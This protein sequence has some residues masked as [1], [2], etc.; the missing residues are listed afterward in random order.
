M[1]IIIPILSQWNPVGLNKA[2]SDIRRAEGGF[3]KFKAGIKSLAVPAA[4]TFAAITAGAF[5]TIKAAEEAQVANRRLANVL[6]QMGYANATNRVLDYADALSTQI[7]KEDESIKLVQA[8]LATFKNL[9]KTIDQ[10]NGAF[11][12]ATRAA[13]DLAAA[14]FGEAEQ[15]ATQLGKALQDPIKGITALARSGVTFT[16]AEKEKIKALVESGKLLEAQDVLL[17]AIETQVGGTAEATATASEKMKIRFGEMKEALG[18]QLLPAFERLAPIVEKIF[19]FIADNSDVFVTLTAVIAGTTA[20]VIA[21]NIALA[22]NPFTYIVLG[23][24]AAIALIALAIMRFE[25]LKLTVFNIAAGIGQIFV[26]TFNVVADA[27]TR[28]VNEFVRTYN[29]YLLPAIKTFKKDAQALAEVDFT[30]PFDSANA[31]ID[32]FGAANR[33]T[34]SELNYNIDAVGAVT[35][36]IGS[37]TPALDDLTNEYDKT[38]DSADKVTEAMK[39]QKKAAQDAAKA[40]VDDLEKSLQSAE[41]QL[42]AVK[43]KF[44]DLKDTISGSVTDVIDFGGAL[45]SGN[46]VQGLVSQANAAKTFA[47]KVKQLIQLGLSER[48]IRQVLD[49]GFESGTLIADQ[50]ILGGSTVVQQINELVAS[51]AAVAD[52]VGI[53][54]AQNFYQAGVD[55]AQALVNGILSQLSAAQAAYKALTDVTGTTPSATDIAPSGK[56]NTPGPKPKLDTSKLTTSAVSKI[57]SQLGGRSDAAAR[58][59]TALAQAYGIT[60]FAKGGIVTQPMMGMVGE[61]GPEAIIPLNKAG[62]ALGNTYNITVNA[63]MGTDGASVGRVIVDAIKKFEKTSG[64]VFASA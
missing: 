2:M 49:A 57:A 25:Y 35:D 26:Y 61:A 14:G 53:Q 46:F 15:S 36:A 63:G 59:Y 37:L 27:L 24:G 21:L 33:K 17:K 34:R 5:S 9:T 7:G 8:K 55:S 56:G 18:Q 32:K 1:A 19:N 41:S 43:N 4:A 48:G 50:I 30:K 23:I 39:A 44:D 38:A 10:T 3:N 13:F 29:R 58:S 62:G 42:D 6:K 64:P 16:N 11:D 52:E 12:R 45:E 31:A 54:G 60:K 22:L 20:A 51:V 47:D 40:I 28:L